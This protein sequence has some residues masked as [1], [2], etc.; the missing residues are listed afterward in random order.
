MLQLNLPMT[1]P[2]DETV[3]QGFNEYT[4]SPSASSHHRAN[5]Y[6]SAGASSSSTSATSPSSSSSAK[7]KRVA[8]GPGAGHS[9]NPVLD[10]R[11]NHRLRLQTTRDFLLGEGRH[12]SVYLASW[13]PAQDRQKR[14]REE[15][16]LCAAKRILPDPESQ[17]AG[18]GEAFILAKLASSSNA[19]SERVTETAPVT[20]IETG[21]HYVMTLYG[22]K[23]E[24][25]GVEAP[26]AP[27]GEP[28]TPSSATASPRSKLGIGAPTSNKS[29]QA[30]R[31]ASERQP[32]R[33]LFG[34]GKLLSPP[35]PS[36]REE[37]KGRTFGFFDA[38]SRKKGPRQSA[39]T[40][41]V[42]TDSNSISG[43]ARLDEE[44]EEI[45]ADKTTALT[46][47]I[48]RGSS[49]RQASG[50][51]TL[52]PSI[53]LSCDD[54]SIPTPRIILLIEFCPFGHL[55]NHI[56]ANADSIGRAQWFEWAK[57]LALAVAWCHHRGVL[58]ADI[59]P[60]NV[61]VRSLLSSTAGM[62]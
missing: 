6:M 17:V 35:P 7:K 54:D 55:M 49:V 19:P 16:S 33:K 39:P 2:L 56:R 62:R 53:T 18:L 5:S 48:R 46:T 61:L 20:S 57:Q 50:S 27:G 58:H 30:R 47:G 22:V 13:I 43:P 36:P 38:M 37:E 31:A 52:A 3:W 59:K 29:T 4:T 15:W 10:S 40:P 34:N 32:Y 21:A 51:T 42:T 28:V 26:P 8:P 44:E 1:P 24:R 14:T 11:I 41:S 9:T 45:L 12:A 60:Q 25:D 23:D